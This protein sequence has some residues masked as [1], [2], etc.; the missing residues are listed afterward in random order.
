MS[1]LFELSAAD[2]ATTN[3]DWYTPRWLFGAAGLV[4]DVDVC[5][6]VAPASRT[7]PAR[8]YLTPVEDGLNEPWEGLVW[9]NP[10]YSRPAPWVSRWAAHPDGLALLPTAKSL[11]MGELLRAAE[12]IALLRV[13]FGRPDGGITEYPVAMI[14]AARGAGRGAVQR[15]SAA[16]RHAGGAY[17]VRPT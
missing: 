12:E 6:P 3:D 9:M 15:V 10:P 1:A 5:A 14:L 17:F 2:V 7:C 13:D 4:F 16:D 11:W 8:R